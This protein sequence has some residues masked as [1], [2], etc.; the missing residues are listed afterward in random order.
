MKTKEEPYHKVYQSPRLLR[1][2]WCRIRK[3]DNRINLIK[4]EEHRLITRP[5]RQVKEKPITATLTQ[6]SQAYLI[7]QSNNRT[8]TADKQSNI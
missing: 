4:K 5:Y 1:V 6:E 3:V 7:L 8:R 2:F